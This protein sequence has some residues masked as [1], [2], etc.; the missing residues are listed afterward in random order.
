MT[1]RFYFVKKLTFPEVCSLLIVCVFISI[2]EIGSKAKEWSNTVGS[3]FFSLSPLFLSHSLRPSL[4]VY[5]H[6]CTYKQFM[7]FRLV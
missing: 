6:T 3:Q 2:G 5:Q 7:T 4:Y 1:T